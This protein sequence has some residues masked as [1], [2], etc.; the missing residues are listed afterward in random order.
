MI[1]K[2]FIDF[3]ENSSEKRQSVFE[4][5]TDY[6][7]WALFKDGDDG[8]FIHIYKM[9]VNVLFNIGI[10]LTKDTDL[11]KD[12]LQDFFIDLRERKSHLSQIDNI[13]FYLVKAFRRRIF[14]AL[15]RDKRASYDEIVNNSFAVE[16]AF[17][18]K[19]IDRQF[20]EDQ[21][22]RL[23][24]AIQ[25]LKHEEREILYYYYYQDFSYSQIA[26]LMGYNYISSARR[27]VYK[28]LKKL[29]GNFNFTLV[30]LA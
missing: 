22:N 10:Q 12:C 16:L 7:V 28:I 8:A 30:F 3:T 29:K 15:K 4:G 25:K 21:L 24:K 9:Y 14:K 20:K 17:D 18:T 11:I 2:Q 5:K 26:D 27:S 19:L 13:K 1:K 6:E 23:N